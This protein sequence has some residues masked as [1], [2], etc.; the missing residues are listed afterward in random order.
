LVIATIIVIVIVMRLPEIPKP[1][2]M[3]KT[4]GAQNNQPLI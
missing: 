4:P 1:S 2:E 3:S